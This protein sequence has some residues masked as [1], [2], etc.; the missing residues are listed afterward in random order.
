MKNYGFVKVAAGL[1]PV[2]LAD[3]AANSREMEKMITLAVKEG[4]RVLSFAELSLTGYTCGDLFTSS[5]LLEKTEEALAALLKKT[6]KEDLIFIVGLP[7]KAGALLLNAA[8]VCYRGTILGVIPKTYLSNFRGCGEPRWFTSASKWSG[9]ELLLAGQRVAAGTDLIFKAGQMTFGVEIGNDLNALGLGPSFAACLQ[10]AEVIFNLSAT[11]AQAGAYERICRQVADKSTA[12]R[13]GYVYTCAGWGESSTDIVFEPTA[14]IYEK[15]HLLAQAKRFETTSQLISAQIDVELL[16]HD[17]QLSTSFCQACGQELMAAYQVIE[18]GQPVKAISRLER[19]ISTTPF[20]PQ[21]NELNGRCEEIFNI[22]VMGLATR[23]HNTGIQAVTLGISGGLDSTLA[24]LVC[25]KTFDKLGISRKKITGI[26]MPG[27]GT[28]DRTYQNALKLMKALGITVREISIKA[29]CEQHF[30]DIAHKITDHNA[31][32]ENAQARERTQ[33]LMDVANQ[34]GAIVVGTGDLSELALGWATYNGDHMA[35]YGVNAD[36][37][38]TLVRS[39]VAW[40]AQTQNNATV[41]SILQDVLATPISPELLPA[42]QGKMVQKTEDLVGPY[43]LHDFF[44]YYF[45]RHGFGPEKIFFLAKQAFKNQFAA[46]VIKKWLN[47][48]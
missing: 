20:V 34:T 27:F 12:A 2:Y 3:P 10:G 11:S 47:V 25:A 16:R 19:T 29:A 30:K 39:L 26:T 13:C 32:Y 8:A 23:L 9:T 42:R 4:V 24:L 14:F 43:E 48:F 46:G 28:T 1:I 17:R 44:L 45:M 18:S 6:A 37:P 41:R 33:I 31:T 38:K 35:M 21:A 36:V 15:D 40:I 5:V 7:V 22:Q